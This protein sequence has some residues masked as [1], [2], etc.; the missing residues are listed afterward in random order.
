MSLEQTLYHV[1][2]LP[3]YSKLLTFSIACPSIFTLASFSS[4]FVFTTFICIPYHALSVCNLST[5]SC[6]NLIALSGL[7][8]RIFFQLHSPPSYS[9]TH[10]SL[11]SH[12]FPSPPSAPLPSIRS[13]P[14]PSSPLPFPLEVG[15][16]SAARESGGAL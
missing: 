14:L 11:L 1:N 7:K 13:P 8:I 12:P 6:N 5:V 4:V 15:P 10:C 3:R 16:L 9:P 2:S